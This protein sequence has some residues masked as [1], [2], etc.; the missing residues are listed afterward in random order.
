MPDSSNSV[1]INIF[2]RDSRDPSV[3]VA[4]G[5]GLSLS[6][7]RGHLVVSD[8]L[9]RHRR[10]RKLP[11][12]QRT[13]RRIVILG[14]TGHLTLEAIRW[15]ADTSIALI[16]LHADGTTL[17]T[18]GKPG[19]DDARLRRA[20]AAAAGSPVGV[21]LTR[22]LLRGRGSGRCCTRSCPTR[23]SSSARTAPRQQ[24]LAPAAGPTSINYEEIWDKAPP[25][26]RTN[27]TSLAPSGPYRC[28]RRG[29][30]VVRGSGR[31]G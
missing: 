10:E 19:T 23:A 26:C 27:P 5:Y 17:L 20:Q 11:R 3:L 21:E 25:S 9:G 28:P 29:P 16:Q 22:H 8:G 2:S 12:A 14:H 18:A 24:Q 4:D 30:A 15:C 13:V 31:A 1:P 7:S 6:V